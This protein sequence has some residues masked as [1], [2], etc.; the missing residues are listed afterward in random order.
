MGTELI[1][2]EQTSVQE[3]FTDKAKLDPILEKIATEARSF[4][5]D[6]STA[7]GRKDIASLAYKVAQTKTY[8]DGLGKDL[9]AEMKRLPGL[10]DA[11]RKDMRD[12]LDAL[13][14]EVRKP[15]DDWEAEQARIEAER[16]AAEEAAV[17]A[18]QVEVDHEMAILMAH[19]FDRQRE[20]ERQA[21]AQAQREREERIAREAEE[22]TRAEAEAKA[23]AERDA[24][25]RREAEAKLAAERA[26]REKLDAE[27]RA[28]EAEERAAREKAEDEARAIQVAKEAAEREERAKAAAVEQ[29][30]LR[31]E[32]E[33]QRQAEEQA[34]REANKQHC[35]AINQQVLADLVETGLSAE[36]AKAVV[37]ALAKGKI[38]HTSI[39]Y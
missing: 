7:K 27:R 39:A 25:L 8:L 38:R 22:R 15:L 37:I 23:Q 24:V 2:L 20:A 29:E 3:V 33:A 30:R 26:E 6:V 16:K 9:V 1:V 21:A 32:A 17:L 34:Q 35:A 11:S 10:V 36:Q 13:K 19:E 31:V 5:P 14:E 4:V 28:Q 18:K 12:F